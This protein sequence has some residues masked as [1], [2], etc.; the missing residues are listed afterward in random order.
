M[1]RSFQQLASPACSSVVSGL[2]AYINA[3]YVL[4]F[5]MEDL[6]GGRRHVFVAHSVKLFDTVDWRAMTGVLNMFGPRMDCS[7]VSALEQLELDQHPASH[8]QFWLCQNL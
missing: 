7:L 2:T 1:L 3:G 5:H 6:M 4:D 8:E